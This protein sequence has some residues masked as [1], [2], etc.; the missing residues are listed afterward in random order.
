LEATDSVIAARGHFYIGY[1]ADAS[2]NV[3]RLVRSTYTSS[4]YDLDV[5]R[6]GS[7]NLVSLEDGSSMTIP[8][9]TYIGH[10]DGSSNNVLSVENSTF[11]GD[12]YQYCIVNNGGRIRVLGDSNTVFVG[13]LLLT[14]ATSALEFRVDTT[15]FTPIAV[16]YKAY[17]RDE[18]KVM[19]DARNLRQAGVIGSVSVPLLSAGE[20]LSA[21]LGTM[22]VETQPVGCTVEVVGK[23]LV[24]TK[25]PGPPGTTVLIQ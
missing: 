7:D 12:Q 10:Y 1:T 5:G 21:D 16:N 25:V 20:L 23:K 13:Q 6:L 19:V 15:N 2:N 3:V 24:L 9:S 22:T 11:H 8:R 17:L 14:N 4:Q 18:T